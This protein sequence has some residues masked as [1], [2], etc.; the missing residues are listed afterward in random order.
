MKFSQSSR[1]EQMQITQSRVEQV[2]AD[3]AQRM[4]PG[5]SFGDGFPFG[6]GGA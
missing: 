2:K 6:A 3:Y 1:V 4:G 5:L